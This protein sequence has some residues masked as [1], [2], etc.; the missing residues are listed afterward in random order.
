MLERMDQYVAKAKS[1]HY[2]SSLFNSLTNLTF[3][4]Y[5][6]HTCEFD[7]SLSEVSKIS[8]QETKSL[9]QMVLNQI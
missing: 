5:L 3:Y 4:I 7:T 2:Q 6:N 1:Y 8:Y 9:E